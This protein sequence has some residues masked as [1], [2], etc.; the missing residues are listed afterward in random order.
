MTTAC[1]NDYDEHMMMYDAN[2]PG[3]LA[4]HHFGQGREFMRIGNFL[5]RYKTLMFY[6][7][8]VEAEQRF[9]MRHMEVL[10]IE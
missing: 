4:V 8:V 1:R 2:K 9:W 10:E 6:N 5:K 3:P 7:V